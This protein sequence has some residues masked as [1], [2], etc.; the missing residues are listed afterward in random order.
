MANLNDVAITVRAGHHDS[1]FG[2][3]VLDGSFSA[4]FLLTAVCCRWPPSESRK[5]AIRAAVA[6]VTD[7]NSFLR[8][9][10]RQRVVGLVHDAMLEAGADVPSP[11]AENLAWRTHN[12][13]PDN[14]LLA[15]EAFRL[16]TT[17]AAASIPMLSLKGVALAQLRLWLLHVKTDQGHRRSGPAGPRRGRVADPRARGLRACVT[18]RTS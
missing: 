13:A 4:D 11:I 17:F 8:I 14:L 15:R 1:D 18:C 7:W 2:R 5:R 12:I 10:E 9:V 6:G 3:R 16:Q